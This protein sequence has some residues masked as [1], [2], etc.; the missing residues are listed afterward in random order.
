MHSGRARLEIEGKVPP[1]LNLVG[2][3]PSAAP[4]RRFKALWGGLFLDALV[5]A[6]ARGELPAVRAQRLD[7]PPEGQLSFVEAAAA[8]VFPVERDRD[9]GNFRATLE[10]ALGDALTGGDRRAWPHGR[11]LPD[12]TA[13]HFRFGPIAFYVRPREARTIVHFDW[14]RERL[15]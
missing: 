7:E 14:R 15:L 6:Q 8:I 11:W 13:D 2:G 1:S 4:Y 9:E 5:A 10:K 3:R 12:D